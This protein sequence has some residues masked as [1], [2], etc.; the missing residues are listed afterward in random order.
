MR[1]KKRKAKNAEQL[2]VA[3]TKDFLLYTLRE[4]SS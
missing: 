4:Q 2:E 3:R 1:K